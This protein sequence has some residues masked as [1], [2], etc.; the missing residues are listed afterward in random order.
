MRQITEDDTNSS[1]DH[2]V[3]EFRQIGEEKVFEK[4]PRFTCGIWT[5]DTA[6]GNWDFNI[7][8]LSKIAI[9]GSWNSGRTQ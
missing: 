7:K 8:E 2:C 5:I 1:F 6:C 9:G 3:P 4:F